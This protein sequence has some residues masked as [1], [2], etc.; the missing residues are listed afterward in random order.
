MKGQRVLI[1]AGGSGIGHALAEAFTSAGAKVW[2]IDI[3]PP[4]KID[5]SARWLYDKVDV[6]DIV[7]MQ[8]LFDR[9]LT[10]W[11]GLDVLC[12]NAG[13]AGPTA[14]I[15]DQP[16]EAFRDC[17]S[18]NLEGAFI[19]VRG[20]LPM[21]KQQQKGVVLFTSST[22]GLYGFP[23]RSPYSASKW[24]LHGFMKTLAME[25]GPYGVRANAIAPGCVDGPRI[26]EVIRKEAVQ[27]GAKPD[28][29]RRAYESGVSMRSFVT[30]HDIAEMAVFLASDAACRVS[31]QII[32]VDG[33]TENPDPKVGASQ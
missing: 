28:E 18:V 24:A 25:A 1:T 4:T 26:D 22:A 15:E 33:H 9:I 10:D 16:I 5:D 11:N 3:L 29:V 32:A 17:L 31:G 2:V 27:K 19:A 14:L 21:M 23:Y 20:A 8:N 7:S 12:A 30:A 13:T 6:R